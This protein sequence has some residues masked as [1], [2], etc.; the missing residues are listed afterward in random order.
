VIFLFIQKRQYPKKTYRYLPHGLD[1][2]RAATDTNSPLAASAD[3]VRSGKIPGHLPGLWQEFQTMNNKTENTMHQVMKN[4][5]PLY[6][7][8]PVIHIHGESEDC[9]KPVTENL[10]QSHVKQLEHVRYFRSQITDRDPAGG[11]A[12]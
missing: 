5:R 11:E 1:Q 12:G 2:D 4:D 7:D 6:T 3:S 10:P 8:L 9:R